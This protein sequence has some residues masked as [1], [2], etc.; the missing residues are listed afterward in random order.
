MTQPSIYEA[1]GLAARKAPPHCAN[2]LEV[3]DFFA[4]GGG[5]GEGARQAG[6]RVAW[7]CDACP[8]ALAA[9]AAN[10]PGCTHL[11]ATLPLPRAQWPFPTDGR[12]F[13]AHFSPP[14]TQFSYINANGRTEGAQRQAA[15]L[16]RW[17]LKTALASG[18]TSWSLEQVATHRVVALVERV[19]KRYPARVAYALFDLSELGVPQTRTRLLAG[20][21]ELIARLMRLRSRSNRRSVRDAITHPRGTHVRNSR[22]WIKKRR[23]ASGCWVYTKAA[24]SNFCHPISEPSPTV[25]SRRELSWVTPSG[26]GC[27]HA[28]LSTPEIAA[29]QTFPPHYRWPPSAKRALQLI[30]NAF[31]PLVARLLMGGK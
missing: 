11:R 27:P 18:A 4:G 13:H 2:G 7:A 14:C 16:V 29:L 25:L 30:G 12:P 1:L 20:S 23:T 21:P 8:V 17:S 15:H 19:R 6:C 24:W 26:A 5:F 31:P 22:G 9:H 3:F 10:H 28:Q